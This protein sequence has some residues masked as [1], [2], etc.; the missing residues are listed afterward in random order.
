MSPLPQ[1][2]SWNKDC[3]QQK[4]REDERNNQ[5]L[6][7]RNLRLENTQQVLKKRNNE[8]E[9]R[10]QELQ[11]AN[12]KLENSQRCL[13]RKIQGLA[14]SLSESEGNVKELHKMIISSGIDGP[15]PVDDDVVLSFSQLFFHIKQV[16]IKYCRGCEVKDEAYQK[17]CLSNRC[18]WVAA[19]I[20]DRLYSELF[21]SN[22]P[23]FGFTRDANRFLARLEEEFFQSKNGRPP[24][25]TIDSV[26]SDR[27]KPN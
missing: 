23:L 18:L 1:D 6:K 5:S 2:S 9:L 14:E 27:D 10:A 15:G 3:L 20:A 12:L 25:I 16:A 8:L 7:E 17:L 24:R 21:H 22:V 11:V 13:D 4:V 19:A 26:C